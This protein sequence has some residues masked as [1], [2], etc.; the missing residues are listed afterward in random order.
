MTESYSRLETVNESDSKALCVAKPSPFDIQQR[1][2]V[3]ADGPLDGRFVTFGAAY[4]PDLAPGLAMLRFPSIFSCKALA[5]KAEGTHYWLS[6][7]GKHPYLESPSGKARSGSYVRDA[8]GSF[9]P[10][11]A[12][13]KDGYF[14]MPEA[15]YQAVLPKVTL[16]KALNEC[17][18]QRHVSSLPN[19]WPQESWAKVFA[20]CEEMEKNGTVYNV[21]GGR[22]SE[23]LSNLGF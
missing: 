7:L 6:L 14:R 12:P 15:F 10:G 8:H 13:N 5:P 23:G 19:K 9:N 18:N 3:F 17:I 2:A 21:L 22:V 11:P 20:A 4:Y 1:L 16:A